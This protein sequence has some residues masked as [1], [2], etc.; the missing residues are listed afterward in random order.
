MAEQDYEIRWKEDHFAEVTAANETEAFERAADYAQ[1][2]DTRV[3]EDEYECNLVGD[4]SPE[5]VVQV[6]RS[7]LGMK[8]FITVSIRGT[9]VVIED[10]LNHPIETMS[11][12]HKTVID[13][14]MLEELIG[15][16]G[17]VKAGDDE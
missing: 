6:I 14:E 13:T 5:I 11:R 2:H 1:E 16:L 3:D 7:P 15:K 8:R 9:A 10:Y 12:S 4:S 17:Y